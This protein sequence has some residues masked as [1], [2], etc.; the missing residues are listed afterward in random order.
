MCKVFNLEL[1]LLVLTAMPRG[2]ESDIISFLH[3]EILY[4]FLSCSPSSKECL[5]FILKYH[6]FFTF[7]FEGCYSV[8]R[9]GEW[10]YIKL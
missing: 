4:Y 7:I 3:N 2:C 5:V 9:I 8:H 1:L 10:D 6:M